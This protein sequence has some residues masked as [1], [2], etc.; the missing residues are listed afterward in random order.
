MI[1]IKNTKG[2]VSGI[3]SARSEDFYQVCSAMEFGINADPEFL[4]LFLN[5]LEESYSRVGYIHNVNVNID[6]RGEGIGKALLQDFL[7]A[8]CSHSEVDF[9]FALTEH[10]Q[11]EGFELLRFYQSLGFET[12]FVSHGNVCMANKGKAK[13]I[14]A[15]MLGDPEPGLHR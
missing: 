9:L 3:Y 5:V 7:R 10:P 14:R 4:N 8:K 13:E 6:C 1:T 12:V 15:M 2:S 11:K